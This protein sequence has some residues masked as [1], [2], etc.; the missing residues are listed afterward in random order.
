MKYMYTLLCILPYQGHCGKRGTRHCGYRLANVVVDSIHVEVCCTVGVGSLCHHCYV[1]RQTVEDKTHL[2][3]FLPVCC[4]MLVCIFNVVPRRFY[5]DAKLNFVVG[6]QRQLTSFLP[7]HIY[8]K[9]LTVIYIYP[10]VFP[11]LRYNKCDSNSRLCED[12]KWMLSINKRR[13]LISVNCTNLKTQIHKETD[14]TCHPQLSVSSEN[15][16]DFIWK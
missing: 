4:V 8:K 13:L 12:K 1:L 16:L 6:I 14:T 7:T 15:L 9:L 3:F 10:Q 2:M 11:D 5:E